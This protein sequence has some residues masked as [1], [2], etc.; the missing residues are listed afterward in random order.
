MSTETVCLYFKYGFCKH[1]AYCWKQHVKT[2]CENSKCDGK[3]CENRHPRECRFYSHY[4]RCKFGEF[5]LFD[6]VVHSDPVLEELK[7]VKTKLNMIEVHIKE[8][9]L[10]IKL[11]F[12][13]LELALSKIIKEEFQENGEATTEDEKEKSPEINDGGDSGIFGNSPGFGASNDNEEKL[14]KKKKTKMK[15]KEKNDMHDSIDNNSEGKENTAISPTQ[16]TQLSRAG[17][18]LCPTLPCLDGPPLPRPPSCPVLP[19]PTQPSCNP[20]S[21]VNEP[22]DQLYSSGFVNLTNVPIL[23]C[24]NC[25]TVFGNEQLLDE[26][27]VEHQFGCDPCYKCFKTRLEADNHELECHPEDSEDSELLPPDFYRYKYG[28]W[29]Y[30]SSSTNSSYCTIF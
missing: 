18:S 12:E 23:Q 20:K 27:Y 17:T 30:F 14:G 29:N 26:H 5:C 1:G 25:A 8:K 13:K 2:R 9:D 7:L 15:N 28:A 22:P 6:H 24:D 11:L 16:T 21:C 4:R 3:N 10:E 19:R